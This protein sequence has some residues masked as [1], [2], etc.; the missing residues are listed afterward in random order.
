MSEG[1]SNSMLEAMAMGI[2]SICT[3]CPVG[4]A[5]MVIENEKNG[6]L[7][8]VGDVIALRDAMLKIIEDKEFAESI[9]EEAVKVR[10]KYSVSSICKMWLDII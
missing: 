1:I 2:P 8:P 5:A 7:I 10:E 4:G 3:D 9:S 6:I